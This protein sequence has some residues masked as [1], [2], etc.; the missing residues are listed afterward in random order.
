[1]K[2]KNKMWLCILGMILFSQISWFIKEAEYFNG[3]VV[4]FAIGVGWYG[5]ASKREEKE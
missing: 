2:N 4:I 1:M 5:Y 3:I